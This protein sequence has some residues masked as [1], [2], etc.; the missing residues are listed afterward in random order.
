MKGSGKRD[1][2]LPRGVAPDPI[3]PRRQHTW[4]ARGA[5]ASMSHAQLEAR[6]HAQVLLPACSH[7]SATQQH[8]TPS[9]APRLTAQHRNRTA[10]HAA[11]HT[12][13]L[14]E[15]STRITLTHPENASTPLPTPSRNS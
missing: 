13:T 5:A 4:G 3:A 15:I 8:A 9:P 12:Q 10:S 2:L 14:L 7:L 11:Q 1:V 6:A